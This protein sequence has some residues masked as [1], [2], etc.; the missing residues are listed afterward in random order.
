MEIK[1]NVSFDEN[2]TKLITDLT[3][4]I[5]GV[6]IVPMVDDAET[7][8][9][10]NSSAAAAGT[11]EFPIF[12]HNTKTDEVGV[13]NTIEEF[14]AV[15]DPQPKN[16]VKVPETKYTRL[17][18]QAEEAAALKDAEVEEEEDTSAAD[19]AAAKAKAKAKADAAAEKKRERE[20]A[21]AKKAAAE[22][23]AEADAPTSDELQRQFV[24]FLDKETVEE[25]ELAARKQF[26]RDLCS[27]AGVTR[28]TLLKPEKRQWALDEIAKRIED[29][30]YDIA[31]SD[32]EDD[33]DMI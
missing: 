5:R 29:S 7:V 4:A 6:G 9:G 3:S 31:D 32:V 15:K 21:K 11:H 25:D 33:D 20:E 24:A 26:V 23:K 22:A 28:V 19:E 30:S 8:K 1:L 14:Q 18:Q 13:A 17:K 27:R 10:A 2:T 12:W 16:I